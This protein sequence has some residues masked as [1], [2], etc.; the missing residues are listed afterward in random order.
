LLRKL[1]LTVAAIFVL[2][3]ITGQAAQATNDWYSMVYKCEARGLSDP[4]YANT[5]NGFFFGPQFTRGTWHSSG[6]GPVREMGDKYGKPMKSY[7]IGYIVR[8]A[9]TTLR[10]Q[11]RGAWPNC[12]GYL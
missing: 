10:K 2:L 5:G 1:T 7:S 12:H 4:W 3:A 6:G 8:I 9:E 11:G